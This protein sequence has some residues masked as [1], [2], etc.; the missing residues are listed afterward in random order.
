MSTTRAAAVAGLAH[1][2]ALLDDVG[3]DALAGVGRGRAAHVGDEVE[4]RAVGL[5]ADGAHDGG[6]AGDD[7]PAQRLVA[8]RQQ[9]LDAAAAAGDDDDVD[10]GQ[11]VE[12]AQGGHDLLDGAEP[13]HG[14]L[15]HLDLDR[16]PAAPG[17]LE[18]VALGGA[19]AAGDQPDA[20]RQERQRPLAVGGEQPLRGHAAP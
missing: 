9:V 6:A 10:L 1:A 15:A 5:V 7:R 11:P 17:V 3:H 4:Q 12:L 16:G 13:L 8:E 20:A 18:H 19:V 2:L 14:D